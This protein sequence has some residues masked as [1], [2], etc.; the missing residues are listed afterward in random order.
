MREV[1]LMEI[2]YTLISIVED[3]VTEISVVAFL[4]LE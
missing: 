4:L 3:S 1:I 2:V